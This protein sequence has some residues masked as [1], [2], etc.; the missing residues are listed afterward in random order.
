[1][2]PLVVLATAC[3][4]LTVAGCAA[5]PASPPTLSVA[6]TSQTGD[7]GQARDAGQAGDTGQARDT[8]RAATPPTPRQQAAAEV[9][10]LLAAFARPPGATPVARPPAAAGRALAAPAVSIASATLVDRAAFWVAPGN[11]QAVLSFEAAH[12]PGQF[13]AGPSGQSSSPPTWGQEFSL[14]PTAV[15]KEIGLVVTV[16]SAGPGQTAI[17]VDGQVTWQPARPAGEAVPA[18]ARLVTLA[19]VAAGSPHPALP[20]PV[21]VSASATVRKIAALVNGLPLS[22]IG[23]APCPMSPGNGLELTFRARPGGRPLAVAEGPAA[24]S[25]LQLSVSGRQQ[26]ALALSGSFIGDVLAAAGLHW[27]GVGA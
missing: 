26:P 14:A 9:T 11:P 8:G 6:A 1:M 19:E 3:A 24:C 23:T 15:L 4:A 10:R 17:R 21:T 27:A 20:S 22:T 12:L 2:L 16:T 18:S 13:T 7:T 25:T 5:R